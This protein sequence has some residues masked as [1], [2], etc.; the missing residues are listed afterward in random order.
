MF[1]KN[2]KFQAKHTALTG[3]KNTE[4]IFTFYQ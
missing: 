4:N 2:N 1:P 3:S